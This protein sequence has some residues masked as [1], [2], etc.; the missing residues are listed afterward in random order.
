MLKGKPRIDI[1]IF[2]IKKREHQNSCIYIKRKTQD[3]YEK[4]VL[5]FIDCMWGKV[6][7]LVGWLF[8][9]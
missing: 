6:G 9:A 8:W 7:W 3:S 2:L 5:G 4:G 1:I